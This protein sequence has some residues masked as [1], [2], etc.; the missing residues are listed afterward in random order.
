VIAVIAATA[1]IDAID[2]I[3][4]IAAIAAIRKRL[5][6][7]TSPRLPRRF[8]AVRAL[9]RPCYLLPLR[10]ARVSVVI[11]EMFVLLFLSLSLSFFFFVLRSLLITAGY[12]SDFRRTKFSR[13]LLWCSLSVI[14]MVRYFHRCMMVCHFHR[15]TIVC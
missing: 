3:D 9:R 2:A 8:L 13:P 15:F 11:N 7:W 10:F 12:S 6:L 14:L 1:A 5:L 4:A